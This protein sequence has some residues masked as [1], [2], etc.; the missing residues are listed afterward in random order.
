MHDYIIPFGPQ[1]PSLLESTCLRVSLKGNYVQSARLRPGYMH[2]GME[3]LLEGKGL[4]SAMYAVEHICGI[5]TYAHSG[6]YVLAVEKALKDKVPP[7]ANYIRTMLAEL[8]R[9]NSHLMWAGLMMHEIGFETVFMF[10]WRERELIVDVFERVTGG[11]VHH[12]ANKLLG[13]RY[14]IDNKDAKFIL[15]TIDKIEKK[16]LGY[17]RLIEKN[18]VT[19]ARFRDVGVI[20]KAD[21]RRYCLVGPIAR[22]SGVNNDV[23][24]LDPYMAYPDVDFDVVVDDG[25]DAYARTLVRLKEIIQSARIVKQLLKKMPSGPV[26][27][28]GPL[29]I[30]QAEVYA[31]VEAPRGEDMHFYKIKDSRIE[32]AKIR[33]PTLA[34]IQILEPVLKGLEIG[35]IPVVIGSLDP[36][37]SCMERILVEKDSKIRLLNEKQ[38]RRMYARV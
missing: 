37:F 19:R 16:V 34:Y 21:A 2:R 18:K 31:R 29:T 22:A 32:R 6:C 35:D 23:R 28:Q 17:I 24:K 33:T 36:C 20:S 13:V 5:C 12:N 10:L 3:K 15:E 14:D 27:K 26:G 11:R 30:P 8:E 4:E 25:C 7:R 9:I 1:H 38:F